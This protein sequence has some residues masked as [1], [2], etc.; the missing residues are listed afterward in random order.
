MM[1][2]IRC[3][4]PIGSKKPRTECDDNLEEDTRY[5]LTESD[6]DYELFDVT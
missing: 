1:A 4:T 6:Q 3:A 5:E 2:L